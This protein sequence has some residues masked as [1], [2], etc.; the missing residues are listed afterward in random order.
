MTTKGRT[1][2]RRAA[3]AA[4]V[5]LVFGFLAPFAGAQDAAS[6]PVVIRVDRVDARVDPVQVVVLAD[7]Y[8]VSSADVKV[9]ENDE[10]LTAT[11][12]RASAAG[13]PVDLILVLDSSNRSAQG[14]VF[15]QVKATVAA[16]IRAMPASSNVSVVDAGDSAVLRVAPTTDHEAAARSVES[17]EMS[18]AAKIFNAV[19]RAGALIDPT[20]ITSVL[21]FSGGP[22]IGSEATAAAAQ[23]AVIQN[24]AQLISV[25]YRGGEAG[26]TEAVDKTGGIELGVDASAE[27]ATTMNEALGAAT[28]RL[29]V[30]YPGNT[31]QSVRS[32]TVLTIGQ[33]TDSYSHAGG[34]QFNKRVAFLPVVDVEPSGFAFFRSSIGLYLA[35]ALAFIGIGLAVFSLGSLF[36]NGDTSLEGLIS[37]YSGETLGEELSEEENAIVQTAFVRRAVEISESFAEDRGFLLKVE[38]M[39]ERA[40]VP[41]RPG[42]AMSF[43]LVINLV[44]GA[45]G[46]LI[47]GGLMGSL[48]FTV[49]AAFLQIFALRFRARRRM[50]KFEQQLPDTLQLLAGTLR[51]GYSLPQ[52]LEAVSHEITDPMGFELRRVMTEARLGR[53][54]EDALAAAADRLSSPDFAWA[55]MAIAIQREVGGNLNELLM[56]VSDTM[57]ARE[58][59]K[60]EVAALTAEGKMSSILLGGLPPALGVIMWI[61]NPEYVNVLFTETLGRIML[62]AGVVSAA[63][64]MAW[65]KKVMTINV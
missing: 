33:A 54:L 26:L 21:V 27:V 55:V 52:G 39:L 40:K 65:M 19:D 3:I 6:G 36:A 60:G 64:G 20:R 2:T 29:L 25:R 24:D 48:I 5:A 9:V 38:E 47:A 53:D 50:R 32:N 11:A 63:I 42:E 8:D 57:L 46:M 35:V 49:M 44:A 59:L 45:I 22:D 62:I 16:A 4:L 56:T 51:A 23:A 58:R 10:T 1:L 17:M 31:D 13:T 28:D 7:N 30:G 18:G 41:L 15:T 61:M 43:W 34:L 37:R 12:Q 14:D